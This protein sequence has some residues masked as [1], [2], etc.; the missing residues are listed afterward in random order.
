MDAVT[1]KSKFR[2]EEAT[3]AELHDAIRTGETTG[4]TFEYGATLTEAVHLGNVAYRVGQP[5]T[6]DA[7]NLKC[8]DCP[9][10]DGIIRRRYRDG[11]ALPT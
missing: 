1:T 8:V 10:A 3:I 9:A 11:W 5:I 6:W 4:S 7:A 2:L